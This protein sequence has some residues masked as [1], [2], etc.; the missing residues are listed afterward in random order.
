MDCK[1][2]LVVATRRRHR[3]KARATR[4]ILAHFGVVDF[5]RERALRSAA[6]RPLRAC[7]R[8][9]GNDR[10]AF[11]ENVKR[12]VCSSAA[13]CARADRERMV[14]ILLVAGWPPRQL[15]NAAIV[16]LEEARR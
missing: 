2:E 16:D 4:Q 13:G 3:R 5:G 7:R 14:A 9:C 15:H 10:L 6:F 1:A 8:D 12:R 11:D